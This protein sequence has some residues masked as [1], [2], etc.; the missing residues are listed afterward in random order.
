MKIEFL[1]AGSTVTGSKYLVTSQHSRVL[2]DCG[3]FQGFKPLRLKNWEPF[4]FLPQ[5]INAVVLTHAHLDHSGAIPLLVKKGFKGPI[6]ATPA[7]MELAKI[8]LLDSGY[9]QEEEARFA[10]RKGY[11]KH[12]PA[13]PLYTRDD[14]EKSLSHFVPVEGHQHVKIDGDLDFEFISSGHLLGASSVRIRMNGK[15]VLF[16]GDIGRSN[17]AVMRPPI[18]PQGA[19]YVV[20][21]ST[22]GNRVHPKDHPIE[23]LKEIIERTLS[24]GGSVLIPSFAVGRA[25]LILY[26][27]KK[28]KDRGDL[29]GVSIYLNS[30]MAA[31]VNQIFCKY[32][33]L[34]RLSTNEA[35]E[36][37]DVAQVVSTVD[38][39]KALNAQKGS[40]III[41]ASGM[42]TGGRVLHHLKTMLPDSRNTILFVGFQAGGTRG[43]AMLKGAQEVKIHGEM[44]P[45]HA[46]IINLESL[47]AHADS[48]ELLNWVAKLKIKPARVFITHGERDSA[49]ALA[50]KISNELRYQCEV[51]SLGDVCEI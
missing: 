42:A 13:L 35:R 29:R 1:G 27:L 16:S 31:S 41:A 24:R 17:D 20:V 26:F 37:C 50:A 45:I 10:N 6:Y 48:E 49:E 43:E 30:P 51:P 36:V 8:L 21:E 46:E 44:W 33:E 40:R 18:Q 32:A 3:L 14:V 23:T 28:L 7:T 25:Q 34:T 4:P 38:E 2:V 39:S 9:L 12:H 15:S 47:S 11:S 5:E 22:Y 19:D